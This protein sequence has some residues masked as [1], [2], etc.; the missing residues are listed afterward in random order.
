MSEG[1]FSGIGQHVSDTLHLN[2]KDKPV[3]ELSHRLN[4]MYFPWGNC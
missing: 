1:E 4:T 2:R 3:L